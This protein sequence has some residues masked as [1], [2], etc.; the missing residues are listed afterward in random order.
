MSFS[1][2]AYTALGG[3]LGSILRGSIN[4]YI[5]FDRFDFSWGTFSVNLIGCFLIG[6]LWLKMDNEVQKAFWITGFLGG[7]TTFSGFGMEIMRYLGD[8]NYPLAV[9]Y[10]ISSVILGIILVWFGQKLAS[11]F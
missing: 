2:Y 11:F 8:K 4:K 5:P 1:F 9:L 10:G 3:A 7:L 6:F